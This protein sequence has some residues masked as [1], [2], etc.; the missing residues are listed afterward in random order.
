MEHSDTGMDE[1]LSNMNSVSER[2]RQNVGDEV[3]GEESDDDL[4]KL[5]ESQGNDLILAAELGKALLDKNEEISK[6]KETIVVEYLHKLEVRKYVFNITLNVSVQA[7]EQE[8]YHLRRQLEVLEDEYQQQAVELQADIHNVKKTLE[9]QARKRKNFDEQS[10]NTIR[11]MTEENQKLTMEVKQSG[12]TEKQLVGHKLSIKTQFAVKK[13]NMQE[14]FNNMEELNKKISH[15]VLAKRTLEKQM[16]VLVKEINSMTQTVEH[17]SNKIRQMER[18]TKNQENAYRNYE[19][20]SDKLRSANQ[21]LLGNLEKVSRSEGSEIN[22][23]INLQYEID[24]LV[25]EYK[26]I[27]DYRDKENLDNHCED[28][29]IEVDEETYEVDKELEDLRNEVR[30]IL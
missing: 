5:L 9:K 24:S 6:H 21:H 12:E 27:N 11:Q 19:K 10:S 28:F 18:K 15:I 14:H 2:M 17:S 1:L 22:R 25:S 23:P 7:L 26:E 3:E 13:S 20:E 8:K 30:S 29:E 4:Y 16:E